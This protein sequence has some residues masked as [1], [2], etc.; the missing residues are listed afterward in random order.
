MYLFESTQKFF[1]A[2]F[3]QIMNYLIL[4]LLISALLLL[5]STVLEQ[6][7]TQALAQKKIKLEHIIQPL[8]FMVVAFFVVIQLTGISSALGGGVAMS[9]AGMLANP[10]GFIADKLRRKPNANRDAKKAEKRSSRAKMK[11]DKKRQRRIRKAS[12]NSVT[13]I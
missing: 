10:I 3:N 13:K 7:L 4:Y 9:T 5:L 6:A 11:R 1:E 8:V 12:K 2:W